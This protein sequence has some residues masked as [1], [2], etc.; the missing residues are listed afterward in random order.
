MQIMKKTN[1]K[2][3]ASIGHSN[4]SIDTFLKKLKDNNIEV[5]VD[6]RTIPMSRFCP[7]FSK[8][9]LQTALTEQDIQYLFRGL[10]LG[11]RDLNVEYED[12]IDELVAM[13]KAGKKICVMCSEGNYLKCHRYSTLTPSFEDR[14]LR[15]NHI[16]YE[17]I[18]RT[19]N[20]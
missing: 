9:A 13:A 17:K 11:G 19:K 5:L 7:H 2:F 12:A 14:G 16:E 20:I 4:V 3:I 1:K 18:K 8:N 10:N 15:V 6:V